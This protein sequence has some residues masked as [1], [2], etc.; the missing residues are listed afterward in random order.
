MI[1]VKEELVERSPVRIFMNSI[2][3]GLKAGE[4]GL[5]ASPSGLGKTS[6]LVQ[7]ALDRLLQGQKVIHVSF[8]KHTDHVLA[9]YEDIFDEFINK[10]NLENK[11]EVKNDIVKNRVLMQFNQEGVTTDQIFGSIRAMIKDGH[12]N[13]ECVI[14]DGYSFSGS[15]GGNMK[16]VK[17]YALELGISIWYSCTVEGG[18]AYDKQ[19]IPLIV[20]DYADSFEV[21][22]ILEPRKEHIAL[23]MSKDRNQRNPEHVALRL[24]PR[25][26]LILK[27]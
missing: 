12:F 6:V 27:E 20:K 23:T 1:M 7:I 24:D 10:K 22:I 21:I 3:G 13:A 14:I 16:R 5:I 8:V 2:H 18:A 9:W 17:E 25:T 4:I 11:T 26:L 19:N 15:D